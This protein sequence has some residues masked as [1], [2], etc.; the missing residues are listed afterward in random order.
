MRLDPM[1]K[2]PNL[3][4]EQ[5]KNFTVILALLDHLR[6]MSK[7]LSLFSRDPEQ[8]GVI[9][10]TELGSWLVSVQGLIESSLA[11]D[12]R[13]GASDVRLKCEVPTSL[14]PVAI[15]PHRLTQA[16]LNLVHNARDAI[17]AKRA[18]GGDGLASTGSGCITIEAAL[19]PALNGGGESVILRVID[20]GC[21]MPPEV[22]ARATEPFFTTKDRPTAAGVGG[23][24]IGL[25]L[26]HA[27]CDRV[28]GS[29]HIESVPGKGTTITLTLPVVKSALHHGP[30]ESQRPRA[31]SNRS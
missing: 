27:I 22:A 14:P 30:H 20:D 26:V 29:M 19:R 13:H 6:M 4:E 7:N 2:A 17:L 28:G 25:S 31:A 8:E 23:S 3:T 24:G 10:S 5:H 15:A 9:G 12:G 11:R 16:V 1:L 21:G 18:I